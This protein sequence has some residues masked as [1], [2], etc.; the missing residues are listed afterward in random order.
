MYSYRYFQFLSS[1]LAFAFLVASKNCSDPVSP[2]A[3]QSN[4][5]APV[6]VTSCKCVA[7]HPYLKYTLLFLNAC[8]NV[9]TETP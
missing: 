6:N 2:P 1:L 7:L 9:S 3:Q 4:S 5:S 8:P